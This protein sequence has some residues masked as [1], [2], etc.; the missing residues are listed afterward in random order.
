MHGELN[1]TFDCCRFEYIKLIHGSDPLWESFPTALKRRAGARRYIGTY[2]APFQELRLNPQQEHALRACSLLAIPPPLPGEEALLG[3]IPGDLSQ[4]NLST[5]AETVQDM[6]AGMLAPPPEM[7]GSLFPQTLE[8]LTC[9]ESVTRVPFCHCCYLPGASCW[10]LGGASTTTTY[11]FSC[12]P[13][14]E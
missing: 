13:V 4:V 10:C 5:C 11:V 7:S 12:Q 9:L 3:G 8:V 14:L 6:A 2:R 1:L